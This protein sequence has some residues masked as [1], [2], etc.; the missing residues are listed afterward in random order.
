MLTRRNLFCC[1]RS[2]DEGHINES[3]TYF[4]PCFTDPVPMCVKLLNS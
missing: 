1:M 2:D 4:V 3:V